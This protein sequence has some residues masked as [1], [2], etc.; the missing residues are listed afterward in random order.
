M[1]NF[2]SGNWIFRFGIVLLTVGLIY[3]V[4]CSTSVLAADE[5]DL[6]TYFRQLD[7]SPALDSYTIINRGQHQAMHWDFL[8]KYD[9]FHRNIELSEKER[10]FIVV[11][12]SEIEYPFSFQ[13]TLSNVMEFYRETGRI[14][15][16]GMEL[17]KYRS[18]EDFFTS[19]NSVLVKMGRG[20][21]PQ[22]YLNYAPT[23]FNGFNPCNGILI[24]SFQGDLDEAFAI[25]ITEL[26]EIPDDYLDVDSNGNK[27]FPPEL[28]VLRLQ[29]TGEE[30]G[31]IIYD[32]KIAQHK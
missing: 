8:H 24:G 11:L 12:M 14:P 30:P 16:D 25:R 27:A 21:S 18:G 13:K 1:Q 19:D 31:R 3:I 5:S 17:V 29:L 32:S 26:D 22:D 23:L 20:Q 9:D 4:P 7:L 6:E 10:R 2:S 15:S 28:V